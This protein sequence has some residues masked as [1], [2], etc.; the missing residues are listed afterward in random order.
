[1]TGRPPRITAEQFAAL[2]ADAA[3]NR[4]RSGAL[5]RGWTP[6]KAVELGV[7]EGTI[8]GY[9]RRPP[10]RFVPP[11]SRG[12]FPCPAATESAPA[13]VSDLKVGERTISGLPS[14]PAGLPQGAR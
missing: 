12:T 2:L 4:Y 6:R 8:R 9:L 14:V 5:R 3:Q 11:V 13:N 10:K 1:M 7:G